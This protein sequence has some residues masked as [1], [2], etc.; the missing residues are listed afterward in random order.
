[1]LLASFPEPDAA[2]M[3]VLSGLLRL[4]KTEEQGSTCFDVPSVAA[5]SNPVR[6]KRH[7][8]DGTAHAV[9]IGRSVRSPTH[10][11]DEVT[12][13]HLSHIPIRALLDLLS[14]SAGR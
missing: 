12:T 3:T 11:G 8:D 5:V 10:T 4:D 14:Q 2:V 13:L 7:E 6:F 1:M 9:E